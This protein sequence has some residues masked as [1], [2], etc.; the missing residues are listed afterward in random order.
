MTV[1]RAQVPSCKPSF[2]Y[3]LEGARLYRTAGFCQVFAR[4]SRCLYRTDRLAGCSLERRPGG[5][6]WVACWL[7][8]S[9]SRRPEFSTNLSHTT[10]TVN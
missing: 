1:N 9:V 3:G 2:W 5:T 8:R 10:N 7:A 6:V 4:A